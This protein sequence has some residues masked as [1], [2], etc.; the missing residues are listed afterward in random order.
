M[1]AQPLLQSTYYNLLT[2]PRAMNSWAARS[3]TAFAPAMLADCRSLN[4][5]WQ[6][7]PRCVFRESLLLLPRAAQPRPSAGLLART[8]AQLWRTPPSSSQLAWS[9]QLASSRCQAAASQQSGDSATDAAGAPAG[10]TNAAGWHRRLTPD[11]RPIIVLVG[12]LGARDRHALTFP[13]CFYSLCSLFRLFILAIAC[14]VL[15]ARRTVR[16]QNCNAL[17]R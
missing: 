8:Q 16:R 15:A 5:L 17:C 6:Q 11:Q 13:H 3:G 1:R 14:S 4:T 12:W 10:A 7:Q 9:R 2:A